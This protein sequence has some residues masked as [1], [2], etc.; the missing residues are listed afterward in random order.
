[1]GVEQDNFAAR[2]KELSQYSFKVDSLIMD[3]ALALSGLIPHGTGAAVAPLVGSYKMGQASSVLVDNPYFTVNSVERPSPKTKHLL[4]HR[5]V[6]NYVQSFTG[7]AASLGSMALPV[8]PYALIRDGSSAGASIIHLYRFTEMARNCRQS[9]TLS[10]WFELLKLMKSHKLFN[11]GVGFS[12]A[13]IPGGVSLAVSIPIKLCLMAKNTGVLA[14]ESALCKVIAMEL[15]WRAYQ[16]QSLLKGSG[17]GPAT[18]IVR[19]LMTRRG[20]MGGFSHNYQ[21]LIQ[22]PAGWNAFAAKIMDI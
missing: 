18:A 15:H 22:E 21:A 19:E 20:V 4:R 12:L 10:Q 16:E 8:N 3:T 2:L 1:M 13:A 9:R 5:K 14:Q 17:S 6:R 11:R 7:T